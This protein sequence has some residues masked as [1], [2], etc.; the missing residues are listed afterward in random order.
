MGYLLITASVLFWILASSIQAGIYGSYEAQNADTGGSSYSGG[1]S[2][3][4]GY[5][6]YNA[7]QAYIYEE[8]PMSSESSESSS[9]SESEE[10]KC[11]KCHFVKILDLPNGFDEFPPT[12][13]Y[14][15]KN[16]CKA[17]KISCIG[18]SPSELV[19]N[20]PKG[21]GDS[22]NQ[23]YPG[24]R[25]VSRGNSIRV[26]AKCNENGEWI[27]KDLENRSIIFDRAVCVVKTNVTTPEQETIV[28]KKNK[29]VFHIKSYRLTTNY[30][31]NSTRNYSRIHETNQSRN[32]FNSR[33]CHYTTGY[34]HSTSYYIEGNHN[35]ADDYR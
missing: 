6:D 16:G 3:G 35:K 12:F 4:N 18:S 32:Y 34:H 26:L 5:A 28:H 13:K 25:V 17:V 19:V 1:N 8:Y 23:T 24:A 10:T 9:S 11:K 15:K 22:S 31:I 30:I 27:I 2:H 29:K 20:N 21:T 14:I 33:S 7:Q